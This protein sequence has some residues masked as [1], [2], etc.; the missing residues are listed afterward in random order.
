M[1]NGRGL[2]VEYVS[3][4]KYVPSS[5]RQSVQ[6]TTLYAPRPSV[7]PAMQRSMH[8]THRPQQSRGPQSQGPPPKLSQNQKRKANSYS[9][10]FNDA[11]NGRPHRYSQPEPHRMDRPN[12]QSRPYHEQRRSSE[13]EIYERDDRMSSRRDEYGDE[14]QPMRQKAYEGPY[15]AHEEAQ[16]EDFPS[17]YADQA[18]SRYEDDRMLNEPMGHTRPMRSS[19]APPTYRKSA[20]GN[21]EQRSSGMRPSSSS[22]G[23]PQFSGEPAYQRRGDARPTTPSQPFF[24]G[25]DI[26][27]PSDDEDLELL[28]EGNL[29]R[30][31]G[32]YRL[33]P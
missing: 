27:R 1:A 10:G 12:P 20:N 6:R 24:S 11:T 9:S 8:Q 16:E 2:D 13:P 26:R 3:H 15:E 28:E 19:S 33:F 25:N 17:N 23:M 31:S 21:V 32:T 5:Q 14:R 29:P 22:G 4:G 7:E 18:S 30:Q